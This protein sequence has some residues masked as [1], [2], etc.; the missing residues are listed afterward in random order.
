MSAHSKPSAQSRFRRGLDEPAKIV[1]GPGENIIEKYKPNSLGWHLG[2]G[3]GGAL[4]GLGLGHGSPAAGLGG[5]LGAII[6]PPTLY[7]N[8]PAGP[9]QNFLQRLAPRA[10]SIAGQQITGE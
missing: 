2:M 6:P 9:M 5:L 7:K 3:A 10:G 4:G 8:V 1:R